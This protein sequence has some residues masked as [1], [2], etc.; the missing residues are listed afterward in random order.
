MNNKLSFLDW[1][2]L[3]SFGVGLY[4]LYIGIENL[5]ENE[6]QSLTQQELLHKLNEHLHLQDSVLSEQTE[7]YLKQINDK[8]DKLN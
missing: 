6:Q 2:T 7:V 4:S 5:L 8:L 1:I 3:L